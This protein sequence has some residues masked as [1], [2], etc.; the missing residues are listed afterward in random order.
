MQIL[1]NADIYLVPAKAEKLWAPYSAE[2][3]EAICASL[4]PMLI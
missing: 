1:K 4:S 2:F 3:A